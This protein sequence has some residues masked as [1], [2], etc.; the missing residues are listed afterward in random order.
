MEIINDRYKVEEL[1]GRGGM[2]QVYRCRDGQLLRTVAVKLLHDDVEEKVV[3]RFHT[4]AVSTAQLNH[5]NILQVLDFGYSEDGRLFLVMEYI[6]GISL[7][8][9][10]EIEDALNL[11]TALS[12][13]KQ[14]CDGLAHAHEHGVIHRDVKPSNVMLV[15][16]EEGK[17]EAKVVDFGLARIQQNDKNLTKSGAALGTPAY[18]SPEAV[19]GK[20]ID[21]RS[22]IYSFGCLAYELLTG[23]HPFEN[24]TIFATMIDHKQ[25]P[26]PSLEEKA[27]KEFPQEVENL[28]ARCLE[29][30]QGSRYQSFQI[31]SEELSESIE[32]ENQK[33]L[34]SKGSQDNPRVVMTSHNYM[35]FFRER[36]RKYWLPALISILAI[37]LPVIAL[38][39]FK[40]EV[41]KIESPEPSPL[42]AVTEDTND[43][44]VNYDVRKDGTLRVYESMS[45]D[46]LKNAILSN[47]EI[48]KYYFDK[49]AISNNA[50]KHFQ[51]SPVQDLV[52]LNCYDLENQSISYLSK[53]HQLKEIVIGGKNI[54]INSQVC[55][56]LAEIKSLERIQ[57]V[58]F[59]LNK[60]S[61]VY[62]N[63]LPHLKSI[64][65]AYSEITPE[66]CQ[67]L[68][69]L[70]H[71]TNLRFRNCQ[72]KSG[73][74]STLSRSSSLNTLSLLQSTV[75]G[76]PAKEISSISNIKVLKLKDIKQIDK[77]SLSRI[78]KKNPNLKIVWSVTVK[79]KKPERRNNTESVMDLFKE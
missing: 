3:K 68:N 32:L 50:L 63:A 23:H 39:I 24:K 60:Q 70:S 64:H 26:P 67:G 47:P 15:P 33:K 45:D 59:T 38:T 79:H 10:I 73:C 37:G 77:A 65:I 2:G 16:L 53:C 14:V 42:K 44:K 74:I 5:A 8:R 11:D 7:A 71:L 29:K 62:L 40:P 66:I 55:E 56:N 17:Y 25:K 51:V 21:T 41:Q 1:L 28:V 34:F 9:L 30:N 49:S 78:K 6:E 58:H 52:L 72:L 43:I 36:T 57:L 75:E 13:L 27:G 18:M 12:I 31:L 4:E 61:I 46:S 76:D 35:D 19:D 69:Q 48:I 20:E 22:D 54:K